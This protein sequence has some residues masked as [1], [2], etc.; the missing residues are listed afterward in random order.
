MTEKLNEKGRD[1]VANDTYK[2]T[3]RLIEEKVKEM[4][5]RGFDGD[6]VRKAAGSGADRAGMISKDPSKKRFFPADQVED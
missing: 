3:R 6:E 4:E 2:A 1:K 5:S